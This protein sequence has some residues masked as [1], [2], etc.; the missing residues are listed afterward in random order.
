METFAKIQQSNFD[1]LFRPSQ[2]AAGYFP[3]E[4]IKRKAKATRGI[5]SLEFYN[6]RV[7]VPECTLNEM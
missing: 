5:Q 1:Q 3:S 7:R 6:K 4:S 2:V